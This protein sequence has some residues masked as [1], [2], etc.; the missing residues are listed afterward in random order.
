ML[1]EGYIVATALVI[2]L[3]LRHALGLNQLR[4]IPTCGPSTPL[5]SYLGSLWFFFDATGVLQYGYNKFSNRVFKIAHLNRW[6]VVVASPELIE[7]LRRAPEDVLSFQEG[8]SEVLQI[9]F[10][11]GEAIS[12][13]P[14]HTP[15]VRNHITKTLASMFPEIHD[16]VAAAC[17]DIFNFDSGEWVSFPAMESVMRIVARVSNRLFVG[18]PLCRNEEFLHL[19]T[20]F[21]VDVAWAATVIGL[22]PSLIRPYVARLFPNIQKSL[23]K[24]AQLLEPVITERRSAVDS[25]D[26]G[27]PPDVLGWILEEAQGDERSLQNL[28]RRIL[29]INFA[30]IHTTSLTFVH[31]LYHLAE[32]PAYLQPLREEIESVV[33]EEG[34]TYTAM[35]RMKRLD[36]FLKESQRLNPL[37]GLLM[38]RKALKPFSFSDGTTI[39]AGTFVSVATTPIHHDNK[40][41]ENALG[42]DGFR[43]S[44]KTSN[45]TSM[46]TTSP[47]F[48]SFGHGKNACPGRY[49]AASE[50]KIMLA[51]LVLTYDIKL[52]QGKERPRNTWIASTCVPDPYGRVSLRKRPNF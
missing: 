27:N 14:Y 23:K 40:R 8:V 46:V 28:A 33:A 41:Y 7:D 34:W 16:E 39:P 38:I 20:H 3:A 51:H 19:N 29:T 37:G 6:M 11:V 31:A 17:S 12:R 45:G 1:S 26:F 42:F 18:L 52:S 32:K 10:T 25:L 9:P 30:A 49:F 35:K 22:C 15:I 24:A 4:H 2:I 48:L 43:F 5:L 36:S 47:W 50:L 21:T 44:D 13:N